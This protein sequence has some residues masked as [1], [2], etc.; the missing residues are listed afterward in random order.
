MDMLSTADEIHS[1]EIKMDR[2]Q[3]DRDYNSNEDNEYNEGNE[4]NEDDENESESDDEYEEPEEVNECLTVFNCNCTYNENDNTITGELCTDSFQELLMC[5]NLY[6]LVKRFPHLDKVF[7]LGGYINRP[8]CFEPI[9]T[10]N[11]DEAEKAYKIKNLSILI[12]LTADCKYFSKFDRI[13]MV[14]T[15]FDYLFKNLKIFTDSGPKFRQTFYKKLQEFETSNEFNTNYKNYQEL[16]NIDYNPC[17]KWLPK[18]NEHLTQ[19]DKMSL[20]LN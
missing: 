6:L 15:T 1:M 4:R 12:S 2:L 14:I 17:S 13:I 19:E 11:W 20:E 10:N 5:N 3:Y 9:I 8:L 7:K 18:I 16:F